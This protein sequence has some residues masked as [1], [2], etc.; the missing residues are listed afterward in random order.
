M[1]SM[2]S[3]IGAYTAYLVKARID[4]NNILD[5]VVHFQLAG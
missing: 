2:S 1:M 5:L 3:D 4:S